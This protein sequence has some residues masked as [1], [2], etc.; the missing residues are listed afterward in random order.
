MV[1]ISLA[2]SCSNNLLN[3][4]LN[5]VV[6]YKLQLEA[7]FVEFFKFPLF[8]SLFRGPHTLRSVRDPGAR[9]NWFNLPRR[10]LMKV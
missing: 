8:H 2:K 10:D 6:Y 4:S 5:R 1:C 3:F 7:F 9:T